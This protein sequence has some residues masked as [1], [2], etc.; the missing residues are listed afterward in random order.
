MIC[1]TFYVRGNLCLWWEQRVELISKGNVAPGFLTVRVSTSLPEGIWEEKCV[2]HVFIPLNEP[3]FFRSGRR[4]VAVLRGALTLSL[5]KNWLC[6]YIALYGNSSRAGPES[7]KVSREGR[8]RCVSIHSHDHTHT[9]AQKWWL[10]SITFVY[11]YILF[12]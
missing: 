10:S 7:T 8:G 5:L 2:V 6:I 4:P 12:F 3:V 1:S 9:E 11:V